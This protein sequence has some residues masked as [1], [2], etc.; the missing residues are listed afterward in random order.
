MLIDRTRYS[1]E[2]SH[3]VTASFLP[4]K[5]TGTSLVAGYLWY[6]PGYY[7]ESS[8]VTSTAGKHSDK[9]Q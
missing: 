8:G 2:I 4:R 9:E 6:V 1:K 3:I 7:L 5:I